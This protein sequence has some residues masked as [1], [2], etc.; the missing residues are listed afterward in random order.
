M[1]F[2]PTLTAAAIALGIA[3]LLVS[4]V[5]HHSL[6]FKRFHRE[7]AVNNAGYDEQLVSFVNHLEADLAKADSISRAAARPK[8][9]PIAPVPRPVPKPVRRI[10]QATP[11]EADPFET[12]RLTALIADDYGQHTAILSIDG[13]SASANTG[14]Q[15]EGMKVLKISAQEIVLEGPAAVCRLG[16]DGSREVRTKPSA[17]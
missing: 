12:L 13:R 7:N 14:D 8:P 3:V 6:A 17:P 16:I 9:Q 11:S 1:R 2:S 4:R 5:Q 15:L 10:A